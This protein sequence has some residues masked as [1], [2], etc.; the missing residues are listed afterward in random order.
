MGYCMS[1]NDSTFFVSTEN[2]GRVL[3]VM[4]HQPYELKFDADGNIVDISFYGEKLGDD[5]K[6]FQKIAPYVR[7]GSFLEMEGED[8]EIWR[9]V[10]QNGKCREVKAKV[11]VTW[12]E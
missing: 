11:H 10:F 9:W 6:V 3:A 2:V 12:E 8:N 1:M 5:L 7:A 4:Q